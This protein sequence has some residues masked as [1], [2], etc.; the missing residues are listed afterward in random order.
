MMRSAWLASLHDDL[1]FVRERFLVGLRALD[2]GDLD[3]RY[4]PRQM[5]AR[6]QVLHVVKAE[7]HWR[8]RCTGETPLGDWPTESGAWDHARLEQTLAAERALT[9]A[10]F[11]GLAEADL[12]RPVDDGR[13]H[14]L[15]VAW[16]L[17]HLVRHDA[18]HA[19]Q[20][21]LIFRLRHPDDA[22]PSGYANIVD[23]LLEQ[24]DE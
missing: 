18:H 17:N 13:G 10:W 7:R 8:S 2:P 20:L 14:T 6:E 4:V 16:V 23:T 15:S 22:I 5:S 21:I 12:V 9:T 24:N 1:A 19:G 3:H 11:G